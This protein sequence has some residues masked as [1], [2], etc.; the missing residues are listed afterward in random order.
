MR[1]GQCRPPAPERLHVLPP[2]PG[3]CRSGQ[4]L[5][6][7]VGPPCARRRDRRGLSCPAALA[8]RTRVRPTR[9]AACV[10]AP[11]LC[12]AEGHSQARR[13]P[14]R[15]SSSVCGG[16]GCG[17]RGSLWVSLCLRGPRTAPW[18]SSLGEHVSNSSC[19]P[20]P[21]R[22]HPRGPEGCG[23]EGAPTPRTG[24]RSLL[25]VRGLATW[26]Q[27]L[28]LPVLG[29]TADLRLRCRGPRQ[30]RPVPRWRVC[31]GAALRRRPGSRGRAP[32]GQ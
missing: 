12:T 22:P 27:V 10:R 17:V 19:R 4:R 8:H 14:G 3:G 13:C 29:A 20:A 28:T 16:R 24:T 5:S 21:R 23:R 26:T 7:P 2:G 6:G 25:G 31:P 11:A 32:F 18:V 9:A 30:G 1:C 15:G